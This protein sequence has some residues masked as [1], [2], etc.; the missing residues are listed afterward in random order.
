MDVGGKMRYMLKAGILKSRKSREKFI[1][2]AS[3][4]LIVI[5]RMWHII[6]LNGPFVFDDEA[7]YWAHA[8]NLSGLPWKNVES[9]WF[10][11]G[12][13]LLL[14]ILFMFSR[15]MAVLY[16][17]AIIVNTVLGVICLFLGIKLLDEM[18]VSC[19]KILKI[20]MSFLAVNYSAYIFQSQIAWAETFLYTWFLLTMLLSIRFCKNPDRKNSFEVTISVF[21]LYVIHNRT[22]AVIV[23]YLMLLGYMLIQKK[24]RIQKLTK[25]IFM[26]VIMV[27]INDYM[28]DHLALLM[29]GGH[30]G[31][32]N[33]NVSSQMSKISVISSWE[34]W[35]RLLLSLAGKLWYLLSSTFLLA[36]SGFIYIIKRFLKASKEQ[37]EIKY[38]YFFLGL[39]VLGTLAVATISTLPQ[40]VD[41]S[42]E[43]RLDVFFYGRYTD[44]LSGILIIMG[45]LNLIEDTKARWRYREYAIVIMGYILCTFLLYIQI[46][47]ISWYYLNITCVPGIWNPENLRLQLYAG[48][49]ILLYIMSNILRSEKTCKWTKMIELVWGG[50]IL[51]VCFMGIANRSYR[52]VIEPAQS[53]YAEHAE[54]YETLNQYTQFPIYSAESNHLYEQAIRTR[55]VEGNFEYSSPPA[56]AE[57]FF[58]ITDT[59]GSE[60]IRKSDTYYCII[61]I[62]GQ[63]L[64][65]KGD[66]ITD[67]LKADG[68]E[69]KKFVY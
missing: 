35:I 64:L 26:M 49:V 8:A 48:V 7:G 68:F 56:R 33:N 15:N 3:I 30:R 34:G 19:S 13:S 20:W 46:K 37:E 51:P 27:C 67:T 16:R 6:D 39:C 47:D 24:I 59:I 36:F 10:S 50:I 45:I 17:L 40:I 54:I 21:F 31:F 53:Y 23:A 65:A 2:V 43:T 55:V 66:K 5:C 63:Y 58:L 44:T 22:L 32:S 29:L 38:F 4:I 18:E 60:R 28:K 69:C 42:K 25:I 52:A 41:Y 11:Y 9:T 14:S 62:G 57:D 61:E 1:L 12:Y